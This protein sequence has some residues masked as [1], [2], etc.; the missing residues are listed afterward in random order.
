[1][2][3]PPHR[4]TARLIWDGNTGT[5][6]ADYT[7][8]ERQFRVAIPG[9]TDLLGSADPSFRG[10]AS[11]HNPEEFFLASI[12]ACHMLVYLAL[13]ARHGVEVTAYEDHADGSMRVDERGGGRFE[14]I[15][16]RPAVVIEGAQHR[17]VALDLHGIAH[18]RCFIANSCSVPIRHEPIVR[19]A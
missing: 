18:D 6:T 2:T 9:K 11:K 1:M 17:R 13:C 15:V 14:S 5:G 12:S 4:Y 3:R 10:E 19:T 16:L 7:A 8:Y